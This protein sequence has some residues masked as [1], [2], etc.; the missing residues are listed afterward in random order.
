MSA[1]PSPEG[2]RGTVDL[3]VH[4][5]ASDGAFPP[6]IVVGRA[7]A[8]G[9]K[10]VALT[11][12]DTLAGVPAAIKAGEQLGVR[13]V[14][15]CEFSVAAP[16]GEMHVLGYFL[17]PGS[18]TLERFLADCRADRERRGRAMVARLHRVGVALGDE[19]VLAEA[20]GGAIGR[21]HVA[22]ALVRRGHVATVGEA[23]DRYLARGKPA[24][25]DK[26]L[27]TF[28]AVA[29]LVHQVGGIVS[30]AHLKERGTRA[31]LRQLRSQGLDAVETRHPSH[32]PD[33]RSR[34]TDHALELGLLRTGGS[35]WHG[36]SIGDEGHGTIGS[37]DVPLEWLERIE[38]ARPAPAEP[39]AG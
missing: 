4:S 27:P 34:L 3:H 39:L 11:D 35:D 1:G 19:D 12:H 8:A 36:G 16:W 25:V 15:G 21:P 33:Q 38:T 18:E 2:A 28:A 37:E 13:V 9:L 30:A 14:S 31:V 26:T 17:P 22:R 23:F 29:T 7:A 10:A 20:E 24:F 6:A 5:S 32:D